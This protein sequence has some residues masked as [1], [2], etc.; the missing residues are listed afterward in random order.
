MSDERA[1]SLRS[2]PTAT[3]K[4]ILRE[5]GLEDPVIPGLRPFGGGSLV[6][7]ARTLRYLPW[8]G[9]PD[10]ERAGLGRRAI[11]QLGPGDVL[12]IDAMGRPEGA[13]LGDMLGTRAAQLGAVG[14][15][16]DGVVRDVGTFAELGLTVFA[17]GTHPD[18][19][20]HHITPWEWEVPIQCGGQLVEPGD[21]ILADAD[22]VLVIPDELADRVAAAGAERN[23]RDEQSQRLLKG[24]ARLDDAYPLPP[25]ADSKAA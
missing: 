23:R 22:A 11:E 3:A 20:R 18:P 15:V 21:W 25:G 8:R 10:P 2:I 16:V 1:D 14:A 17:R 6:G 19:A 7:R 12:V 5:L 4:E 9:Q 13:V 24:G